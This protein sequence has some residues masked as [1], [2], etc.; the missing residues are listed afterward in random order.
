MPAY[1]DVVLLPADLMQDDLGRNATV[2]AAE[3]TSLGWRIT[4]QQ[5]ST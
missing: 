3:L 5:S 2:A 4:V 1:G